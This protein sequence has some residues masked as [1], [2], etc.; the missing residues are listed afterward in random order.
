MKGKD[1]VK[2]GP[3]IVVTANWYNLKKF[4]NICQE[5]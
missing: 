5:T 2:I 4:F 1:A 3:L